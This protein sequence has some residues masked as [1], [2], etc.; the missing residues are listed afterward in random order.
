MRIGFIGCG[1][2]GE[3]MMAGL[4][5]AGRAAARDLMASDADTE[6]RAAVRRRLRVRVTADNREIARWARVLFLAVKPQQMKEVLAEIRPAVGAGHLVVS[7]AAG[8]GVRSME[9]ALPRARVIRVMPNMACQVAEAMSVY[10]AGRRASV[11]DRRR[12][13]RLLRGFGE[14]LELPERL[15][16]AVTALSGSGPAFFA[17]AADAMVEGAVAEGIG[18]ADALRLAEQ[19]LLGT[20]RLLKER[21]IDPRDLIAGVT[22]AKGTTAEGLAVLDRAGARDMFRRTIQAAAR[23][24]RELSALLSA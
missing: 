6:R 11:A 7:I 8:I 21:R 10:T 17:Y 20:A 24:S 1:K 23:R 5:D 19:T 15:F 22:S 13:G 12:V 18:R 4:I 14:A 16:D 9:T 2:M 3:A